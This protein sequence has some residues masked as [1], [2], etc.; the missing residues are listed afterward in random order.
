MPTSV[1]LYAVG[2]IS[3]GLEPLLDLLPDPLRC[4]PIPKD[5]NPNLHQGTVTRLG[6]QGYFHRCLIRTLCVDLSP[7]LILLGIHDL[8]LK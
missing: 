4:I 1:P 8:N 6:L 2:R 7:E 5:P 3:E